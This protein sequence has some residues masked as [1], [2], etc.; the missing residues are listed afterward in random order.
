MYRDAL[1]ARLH[2][3]G[4]WGIDLGHIGMFMRHAGIYNIHTG[5][6]CV[7]RNI[8]HELRLL[9]DQ[10]EWGQRGDRHAGDVFN[11]ISRIH[12]MKADGHGASEGHRARLWVRRRFAEEGVGAASG[13]R[14]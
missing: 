12:E 11:L 9:H 7:L 2:K 8:A 4:L 6:T 3:K 14:V 1:A 13:P 5:R 10:Q